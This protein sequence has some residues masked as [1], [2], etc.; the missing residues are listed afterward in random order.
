MIKIAP[1]TGETTYA[2]ALHELGHCL[3][4]MG[5]LRSEMSKDMRSMNRLT[6]KRD[7]ALQLEEERAAWDWAEHYALEWTPAMQAVKKMCLGAYERRA[8]HVVRIAKG[9]MR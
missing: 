2:V 7:V 5:M 9:K 3:S 4:P 1:V 8:W 6:T